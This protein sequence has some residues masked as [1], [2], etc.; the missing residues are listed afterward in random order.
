MKIDK[1]KYFLILGTVLAFILLIKYWSFVVNGFGIAVNVCDSLITGV[2]IAYV[3]NI[4]MSFY[5][6]KIF[7]RIEN[8]YFQKC[9]RAVSM[10]LS[11]GSIIVFIF[12]ILWIV[13]PELNSCIEILIKSVPSALEKGQK[14]LSDN[15][16]LFSRLDIKEID[17]NQITQ[18][19]IKFVKNGFAPTVGTILGYVSSIIGMVFN[20]IMGLIFSMYILAQKEKLKA[21]IL[22]CMDTYIKS[23][24]NE[25]ILYVCRIVDKSF[26]S[27]IVGQCAEAVILGTLCVIGMLIFRFPYAVMIGVLIGCTALIPIA[28]AYIGGTVGALMIFTVSPFKAV[29]FVVFLVILQQ[30]E[31]Q[32]IYPKV[33]GSSIGLPGIWVFAAVV[34]G[35]GLFGIAGVLFGIPIAAASYVLL[36][37]DINKRQ[38][39]KTDKR[40]DQKADKMTDK[41]TE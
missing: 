40:T 17:W 3:V 33:V 21:Q 4:I 23:E 15:M 20:F 6:K 30:I 24:T 1:K 18:E 11:F 12:L 31:G 41:E 27:F 13:I 29:M 14:M 38:S 36:R 25:K 19:V 28:G 7:D 32:L 9:K 39:E 16:S 34:V 5:E 2:I 26:H 35:G 10:I 22:R 37:N 8:K